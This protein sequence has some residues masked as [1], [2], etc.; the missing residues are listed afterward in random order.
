MARERGHPPVAALTRPL[1]LTAELDRF[2][3][4]QAPDYELMLDIMFYMTHYPDAVHHPKEDLAFAKI[5]E[6]QPGSRNAPNSM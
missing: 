4:G 5:A 2:S 6:R 3:R 1:I